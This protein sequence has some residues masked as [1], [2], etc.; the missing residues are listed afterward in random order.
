MLREE[1]IA[2]Q[3]ELLEICVQSKVLAAQLQNSEPAAGTQNSFEN[4][5]V[6]DMKSDGQLT[7]PLQ[8]RV[9]NLEEQNENY[10]Q[11]INELLSLYS[12]AKQSLE[13]ERLTVIKPIVRKLRRR[14]ISVFHKLPM[15]MQTVIRKVYRRLKP[16]INEFIDIL[17]RSKRAAA[18]KKLKM[19][20]EINNCDNDSYDV[21]VFPVIDWHFRFQR[22]QHIASGLAGKGHRVFYFSTTF[23]SGE[24]DVLIT[25]QLDERVF[26]CQFQFPAFQ[27]SSIY[28]QGMTKKQRAYINKALD[29]FV[30]DAGIKNSVTI[31]DHP[32]WAPVA[33]AVADSLV[34]YDCMDDHSGFQNTAEQIL[35][36]ETYLIQNADRVVTSSASLSE[37]I[38]RERNNTLIRNAADAEWFA[39]PPDQIAYQKNRPVVGYFGAI[40]DWFDI[41]LV[42]K[43]ARE[44]PEYD[45]VLIGNTYQCNTKTA[46]TVSNIHFIG[47]VPYRN[48]KEY[49]YA[50]D[51][52]LIPFKLTELIQHTNPVKLYEYLASGKPVVAT[53]MPELLLVDHVVSIAHDADSFV[54]KI[55]EAY[56]TK[57]E[58]QEIEAR[59]SFAFEN[60]WSNRVDQLEQVIQSTA[61]AVSV[62]VLTYNNLELTH[63]CLESLME[64]T[65][66][67]DWELIVVDNASSDGTQTYL[68]DFSEKYENVKVILNEENVG[69]AAGNNVGIEKSRGEY[70][71]L[72]NND[73]YVTKGWLWGMVRYFLQDNRLGLLGPVTNNIGNEAKIDISYEGMEEMSIKARKYTSEHTRDL[74]NMNTVAFF[75]AMISRQ[76]INEVGVL[77]EVFGCG[78]FEDDDYCIR[79]RNAGYKIAITED[80]FI[81][82]HLSAS[83]NKLKAEQRQQL[84]DKNKQIFEEK[85][86]TWTPHVYR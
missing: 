3:N 85:W 10:S 47:E 38:G 25:E 61:P 42:I 40:S 72:L 56:E 59:K 13:F 78:F 82:H 58:I 20:N 6:T 24:P 14:A 55:R 74:F 66:Y 29:Q 60:K 75:C 64:L 7:N 86:G 23:A 12:E 49:L 67:P 4:R 84:F 52:C 16:I 48:L 81:H 73:T 69:F 76:V 31:V 51:V 15:G 1:L 70:V 44:C 5:E 9:K 27:H 28:E 80:V 19:L 68:Q 18:Q 83:F 35:Q 54:T 41:E 8:S 43:A 21:L 45:F 65:H 17:R 71:V 34:V 79:A 57:D 36:A 22:P 30:K 33:L 37:K 50:F 46:E 63:K 39:Q 11:K 77:D 32:F 2:A 62:I 53:A 26:I